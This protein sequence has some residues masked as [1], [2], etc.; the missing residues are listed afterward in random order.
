MSTTVVKNS[1]P[2][3]VFTNVGGLRH[4]IWHNFKTIV[5]RKFCLKS[6]FTKGDFGKTFGIK[7]RS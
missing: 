5:S 2:G 4:K 7:F 1:S 6:I 3:P